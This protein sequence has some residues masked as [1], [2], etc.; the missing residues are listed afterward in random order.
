[1][2]NNQRSLITLSVKDSTLDPAQNTKFTTSSISVSNLKSVLSSHNYSPIIWRSHRSSDD[3]SFA[4]A[5]PLDFDHGFT[6]QE[7]EDILKSNN[8]NYALITSKS[9]TDSAHRFHVIIPFTRK[10]YSPEDYNRIIGNLKKLFPK[11]DPNAMDAARYFFHSPATAHY[12]DR[13]DGVDYDPDQ[14]LNNEI[15]NAWNDHLVVTDGNNKSI[16]A[17]LVDEKEKIYCPFHTDGNPSAF[18]KR[19]P[20]SDSHFIH[21]STC[22]KT[23]W[24]VDK[25]IH[26][27]CGNFWSHGTDIFEMGIVGGEFH[28]TSIGKEKYVHLVNAVT[29]EEKGN[30]MRYLI[31]EKHIP[32]LKVVNQ[33]G[34]PGTNTSLYEVD[35]DSGVVTVKHAP[36]PVKIEDNDFIENYL[37]DTFGDRVQFIKQWLAV[38]TYTNYRDHATLILNGPRGCGKNTFAEMVY[39]IYP[40]L[41]EMWE[42]VKKNFTPEAE[43]KLLIADETVSDN[44]D[45]YKL[46]KQYSGC[47]YVPVNKKYLPPYEVRNNMNIII[48][49][50]ALIPIFVDGQEIPTC[51]E[52][53]QFFV[54]SFHPFQGAVDPELGKKLEERL[55]QYVR[56]ELKDVFDKLDFTGNRYSIKVP[57][58]DEEKGLFES[59]QT[60][61]GGVV[62]VIIDKLEAML[63]E[64]KSEYHLFI[65]DG[66]IPR[67]IFTDESVLSKRFGPQKVI[68]TMIMDGY[69]KPEKPAKKEYDKV[70]LNSY[71]MTDKLK[72]LI[73]K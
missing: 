67:R 50:N 56:T 18:V 14:G 3:F 72:K 59:N 9:H 51:A 19:K 13:W 54:Y 24:K 60:E 34:E 70:R 23:Y 5:A 10:V 52:N 35:K 29:N 44:Q 11:M 61:A 12:S 55:G 6:I 22:Q 17:N 45:Q 27:K 73:S 41:S 25:P 48:L 63:K 32:H 8:L 33:I 66:F 47:Q 20:D 58:T 2:S 49:S 21:C 40:S 36:L 62:E 7:A 68:K 43:K 57:I 39:A 71:Q 69:L 15:T 31:Q 37:K 42:G 1:M 46:L 28:M 53:N 30:A 4:T 38:Y 16:Y 64:P 65:K 26:Q